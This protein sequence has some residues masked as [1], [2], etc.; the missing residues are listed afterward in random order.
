MEHIKENTY[1][2][3]HSTYQ[4]YRS[5]KEVSFKKLK[6]KLSQQNDINS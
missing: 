2:R 4:H 1:N 3:I 6:Q 5:F